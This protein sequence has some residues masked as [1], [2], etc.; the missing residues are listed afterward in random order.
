MRKLL[1]FVSILFF[2]FQAA[3]GVTVEATGEGLTYEEALKSAIRHAIEQAVGVDIYGMTKVS[4]GQLSTSITETYTR[5]LVKNYRVI[6]KSRSGGIWSVTVIADIPQ[7]AVLSFLSSPS[8]RHFFQ[9][10][11]FNQRR[12]GIL[13]VKRTDKDLPY[14]NVAA[15]TIVNLLQDRLSLYLFRVFI[16]SLPPSLIQKLEDYQIVSTLSK[17]GDIDSVVLARITVFNQNF[18]YFTKLTVQLN[19]KA[20]DAKNG[21]VIAA[22]QKNLTKLF[23]VYPGEDYVNKMV[24][25]EGKKAV[26]E[27]VVKIVKVFRDRGCTT[28]YRLVFKGLSPEALDAVE[29]ALDGLNLN[30][31]LLKASPEE[32][33]Y[34]IITDLSL[35]SLRHSLRRAFRSEGVKVYLTE[36]KGFTLIFKSF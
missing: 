17:K 18:G 4:N 24:I 2:A 29:D 31:R 9:K 35:R 20:F 28:T 25:A 27:L 11:C 13:Y 16:P 6:S 32:T 19:L 36:I 26:N 1:S 10:L 30:Y 8:V 22:V 15:R 12:I 5:G 34:E 21:Q 7:N 14:D 33:V 23:K 3:F